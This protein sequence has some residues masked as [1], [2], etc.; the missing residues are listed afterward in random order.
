[1]PGTGKLSPARHRPARSRPTSS[2]CW[3]APGSRRE[4][5]HGR[6]GARS[7]GRLPVWQFPVLKPR[8]FSGSTTGASMR[9]QTFLVVRFHFD[10]DPDRDRIGIRL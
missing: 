7:R 10:Y 8:V 3:S 1:M 2:S 9:S 4:N 6:P 5:H